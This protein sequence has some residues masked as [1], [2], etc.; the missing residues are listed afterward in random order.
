ML[1]EPPKTLSPARALRLTKRFVVVIS[2]RIEAMPSPNRPSGRGS[3]D[4]VVEPSTIAAE[5][6]K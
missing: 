3:E 4:W 6:L 1:A 2:E 5:F